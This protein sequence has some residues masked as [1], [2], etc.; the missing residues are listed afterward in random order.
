MLKFFHLIYYTV[1]TWIEKR[2]DPW[3][4]PKFQATLFIA[5]NSSANLISIGDFLLKHFVVKKGILN[6]KIEYYIFIGIWYVLCMIYFLRKK[7]FKKMQQEFSKLDDSKKDIYRKVTIYY[8]I[9]S[10]IAFIVLTFL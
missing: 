7:Q 3:D 5:I 8:F 6:F 4:A 1:Y 9:I 10:I 2:N